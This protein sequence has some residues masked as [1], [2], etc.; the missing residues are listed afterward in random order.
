MP[1]DLFDEQDSQQ[2]VQ[3]YLESTSAV[4]NPT[5]DKCKAATMNHTYSIPASTVPSCV[6][7]TSS[8]FPFRNYESS[9]LPVTVTCVDSLP[10]TSTTTV[11]SMSTSNI[12]SVT[13][14]VSNAPQRDMANLAT[15]LTH[16]MSLNRLPPPE[17]II[18][19]GNPLEF[20]SWKKIFRSS[21]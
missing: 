8:Q 11:V 10:T 12:N 21:Y 2:K 5:H 3:Q 15:V 14:P 9:T 13:A 4:E 19:T 6:S 17:P 16:Q 18:F 20:Q 1:P 7:Q